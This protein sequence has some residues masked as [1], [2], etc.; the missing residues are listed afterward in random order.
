M[1]QGTL[2]SSQ[3]WNALIQRQGGCGRWKKSEKTSGRRRTC[4]GLYGILEATMVSNPSPFHLGALWSS[5]GH[6]TSGAFLTCNME[7][8]LPDTVFV[9]ALSTVPAQGNQWKPVAG[10][11]FHQVCLLVMLG[12]CQGRGASPASRHRFHCVWPSIF[13]TNDS[14]DA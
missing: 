12:S 2:V 5:V 6:L 4:T 13:Q 8:V 11:T 9:V 1:P 10:V 3:G 7:I 14:S